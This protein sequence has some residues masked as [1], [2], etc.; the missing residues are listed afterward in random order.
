[1]T[2]NLTGLIIFV[3]RNYFYAYSENIILL[4]CSRGFCVFLT[5]KYIIKGICITEPDIMHASVPVL[6]DLI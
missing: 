6:C 5:N 2:I 4:L 1:M 3:V